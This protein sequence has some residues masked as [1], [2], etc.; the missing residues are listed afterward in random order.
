MKTKVKIFWP[1]AIPAN[2]IAIPL[3]VV[4]ILIPIIVVQ[5]VAFGL[6]CIGDGAYNAIQWFIKNRG[7]SNEKNL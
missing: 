6:D 4:L 3:F 1:G 2:M 5:I 7:K